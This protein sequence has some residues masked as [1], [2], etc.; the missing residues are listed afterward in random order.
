MI[1][2]Y[3]EPCMN[4]NEMILRSN[5]DNNI[6][7]LF[8]TRSSLY[9]LLDKS[10]KTRN[11]SRWNGEKIVI[12]SSLVTQGSGRKIPTGVLK[13]SIRHWDISRKITSKSWK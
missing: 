8:F 1:S 6:Q 7:L 9:E 12:L 2:I 13:R 4:T 11:R 3:T 10:R 5:F